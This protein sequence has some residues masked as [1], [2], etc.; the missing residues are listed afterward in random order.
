MINGIDESALRALVSSVQRDPELGRVQFSAITEWRE[1]AHAT[2]AVRHFIVPSDEPASLVGTDLAPNAVEL[3]LSALGACLTVGFVYNAALLGLE[4][5]NLTIELDGKLDLAS[6]LGLP[7][8]TPAGYTEIRAGCRLESDAS[9]SALAALAAQVI[10]TSPVTDTLRRS[11]PVE[12]TV[13]GEP[14]S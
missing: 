4:I 3:L 8:G 5:R 7:G 1:G 11:V 6:F 13:N 9:T 10:A 14:V 2:T 12:L